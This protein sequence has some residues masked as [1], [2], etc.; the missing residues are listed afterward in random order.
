MPSLRLLVVI[1][2]VFVALLIYSVHSAEALHT[3]VKVRVTP[4]SPHQAKTSEKEV[5]SAT[6]ND[7]GTISIF[8]SACGSVIE[9]IADKDAVKKND[10]MIHRAAIAAINKACKEY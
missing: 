8:V 7:D 10:E 3:I 4:R 1:A 6:D 9:V 5:L 2:A